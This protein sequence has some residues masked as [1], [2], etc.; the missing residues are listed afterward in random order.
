MAINFFEPQCVK[1]TLEKVFGIFD[2]P[3][4]S[5]DF[6]NSDIWIAWVD[7]SNEFKVTFTAIDKCLNIPTSEGERCEAMMTHNDVLIF[8]EL[9]D[10]T[11]GRWAGKSRDQ[12]T[13]TIALFKRDIGLAGY[14]RLYGHIANK[15]RPHFK[16]GGKAFSQKF[17]DETGFVLRVSEVIKID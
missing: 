6:A 14:S 11:G 5:L 17:E 4:A 10:A 16:S 7:N 8:I 9:K 15:Q 1:I 13:N 3:P 2:N 12:L